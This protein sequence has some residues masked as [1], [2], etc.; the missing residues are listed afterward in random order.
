MRKQKRFSLRIHPAGMAVFCMAL[1]FGESAE[2]LAVCAALLWHEA[3]HA[4]ALFCCCRENCTIELTPFG[5]MA[6]PK[7]FER[8]PPLRQAICAGAGVA[9]S[10]LGAWLG[11]DALPHT[12]FWNGLM[13]GHLSLAFVNFLPAWPLDGARVLLAI[14]ACFGRE[15]KMR[16]V[17]CACS[18]VLAA[19]M[20]LAALWGAYH[21]M[22]NASLLVA[23]PYLCYAA[24]QGQA[25]YSVRQL[26]TLHAKMKDAKIL[27]VQ[28]SASASSDIHRQFSSMVAKWPQNHYQLLFHLDD[29]GHVQRIW[30]EKEMLEEVLH[31]EPIGSARSI[32]K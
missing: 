7:A 32:D 29:D 17:L 12:D 16:R 2:V 22:L 5:G 4:A 24:C 25:A 15:Q 31:L 10:L 9:G 1:L 8:M 14:A 28:V 30:T 3:A 20:V 13:R 27:P 11:M 19:G 6:D 26:Q 23:G 21:G 18:W